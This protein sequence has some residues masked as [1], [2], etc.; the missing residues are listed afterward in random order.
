MKLTFR[1][2][3]L[4]LHILLVSAV[5]LGVLLQ[6]SR[7][8]GEDLRR[9]MGQRLEEQARGAALW[10]GEGRHP[11]R[12]AERLAVVVNADVTV[13]DKE[14]RVVGDSEQGPP[15]LRGNMAGEPEVLAARQGG[16]GHATRVAADG[17]EMQYVAV[18]T[19]D[20]NVVRLAVP[21]R[22]INATVQHL[23]TRL[24][25]AFGLAV[26]AA[27]ALGFVAAR[28]A[29]GP[30]RAMSASAARIAAGDYDLP[31]AS[32]TPDEFGELS[33]SL[34]SL[35]AELKAK[36]QDL[37]SE[38]DRIKL[39]LAQRRDL[40]AEV[41]H[42]FRTPVTAIQGYAE[43][44]LAGSLDGQ[45]QRQFLEIIHRHGQR[46]G[47]LV[48]SLLA[49]QDLEVRAPGDTPNLTFDVSVVVENVAATM[50]ARAQGDGATLVVKAPPGL[51]ATGDPAGLEQVIEN[52]VDN[53]LKYG[54]REVRIEGARDEG[55]V[56]LVVQDDGPGI[57]AEHLPRLFERFYRVDPARSRERGGAGLGLAIVRQLVEAMGGR[58]SVTSEVGKGTRFEVTLTA[59]SSATA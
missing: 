28:T 29:A 38:R 31:P 46:L 53:A 51:S 42:E 23:H 30:L 59:V 50:K 10:V 43:T 56:T 12:L 45:N 9:Q 54:G 39:L 20:G 15:S 49:L 11:D 34:A 25:V 17:E 58:V 52:L 55:N 35:A 48:E 16:V 13:F 44:L 57:A 32:T 24:A 27:V 19:T 40:V 41:S 1:T 22:D 47:K 26:L 36:I 37:T 8:L 14:G 3:L 21:L 2:K 7:S 5:V 6:L 33:R 4:A 18:P